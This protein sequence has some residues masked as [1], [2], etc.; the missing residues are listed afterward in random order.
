GFLIIEYERVVQGLFVITDVLN[1]ALELSPLTAVEVAHLLD[2]VFFLRVSVFFHPPIDLSVDKLL[3]SVFICRPQTRI[4]IP[5]GVERAT[6]NHQVLRTAYDKVGVNF[7][8]L[9][10]ILRLSD[11]YPKEVQQPP[12]LSLVVELLNVAIHLV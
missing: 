3:D 12:L 6:S 4:L 8:L 2:N 7:V 5:V 10:L 9:L 1:E 11:F